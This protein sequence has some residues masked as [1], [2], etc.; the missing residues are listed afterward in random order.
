[1]DRQHDFMI[2][3]TLE[4]QA[5]TSDELNAIPTSEKAQLLK[6]GCKRLVDIL[7]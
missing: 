2:S 7:N 1:M 6:H 5:S 4:V 3:T